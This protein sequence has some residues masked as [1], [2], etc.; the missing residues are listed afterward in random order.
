[1]LSTAK[2]WVSRRINLVIF[3]KGTVG[4]TLINQVIAAHD[5]ILQRKN[6]SL[7]IVA[8]AN[9]QKILTAAKGIGKG[10]EE[11]FERELYLITLILY[12]LL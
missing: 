8:I 2:S 11:A 5:N 12:R 3:G 4:G 7:R 9:S 10:W 1:M 6:I